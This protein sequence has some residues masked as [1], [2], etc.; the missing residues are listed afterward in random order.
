MVTLKVVLN[1]L[2]TVVLLWA[3]WHLFRDWRVGVPTEGWVVIVAITAIV[4][5]VVSNISDAME[6]LNQHIGL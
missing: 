2:S 3:T 4:Y 6:S 1:L 5:M